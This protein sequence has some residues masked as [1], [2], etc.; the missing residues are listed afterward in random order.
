[1]SMNMEEE[2][3]PNLVLCGFMG[4]GKSTVGRIA[5]ERLG[6]RFVDSDAC[7]EAEAGMSVSEIFRVLGEAAFREMEHEICVRL[8]GQRGQVVAT[9]GGALVNEDSRAALEKTGVLVLLSCD[10]DV[11]VR[12]LR[13]SARL[14]ERP[15]L[16]DDLEETVRRILEE[17]EGVYGRVANKV[18]TTGLTPE[19]AAEEVVRVYAREVGAG[20]ME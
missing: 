17:R 18:D 1:M 12:R 9:G 4:A 13:E 16:R 7:I 8:A 3:R 5:A 2:N 15:L 14:G 6:M 11:L 10:E 20:V 19:E